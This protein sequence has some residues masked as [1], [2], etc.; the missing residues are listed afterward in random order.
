MTDHKI[1]LINIK[2][3]KIQKNQKE[4]SFI[5][6]INRDK[7]FGIIDENIK[8]TISN[9]E[10]L[11]N[12]IKQAKSESTK[13]KRDRNQHWISD[14]LMT[15]IQQSIEAY[16]RLKRNPNNEY[17]KSDIKTLKNRSNNLRRKL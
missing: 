10:K 3:I 4:T 7:L 8:R 15:L 9:V 14:K 1:Q 13:I 2:K 12:I 6:N 5:K 11:I 17:L 16:K